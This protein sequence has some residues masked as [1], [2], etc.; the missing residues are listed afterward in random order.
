MT[1][2]Y[3]PLLAAPTRARR[4]EGHMKTFGNLILMTGICVII[5]W[6]FIA[7]RPANAQCVYR[8]NDVGR[9]HGY[10]SGPC[11]G[12]EKGYAGAYPSRPSATSACRLKWAHRRLNDPRAKRMI[13]LLGSEPVTAEALTRRSGH[14]ADYQSLVA[15]RRRVC[16]E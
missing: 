5:F 14:T 2:D 10:L 3:D 11:Q 7:L 1:E 15:E 12:A 16:G 13:R 4:E 6:V 9:P 8:M